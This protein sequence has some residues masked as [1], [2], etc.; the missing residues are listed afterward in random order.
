MMAS[1]EGSGIIWA[2][3][4]MND[5]GRIDV[6]ATYTKPGG[7]DERELSFESLNDAAR[8]LGESFR[9]VVSRV[10]AAGYTAGRWRP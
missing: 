5:D 2:K 7:Y 3:W 10:T 6:I 1:D 4:S 8:A 9:Q